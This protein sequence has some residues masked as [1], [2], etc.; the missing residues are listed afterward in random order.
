MEFEMNHG[1]KSNVDKLRERVELYLENAFTAK[2]E[3]QESGSD[4]E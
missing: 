2:Q 1:K 4:S 3:K